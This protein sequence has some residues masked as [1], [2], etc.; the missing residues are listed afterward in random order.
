[1]KRYTEIRYLRPSTRECAWALSRRFDI[2][3]TLDIIRI[4]DVLYGGH[5]RAPGGGF[6]YL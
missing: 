1:M 3:G 2:I 4:E 6:L 5:R